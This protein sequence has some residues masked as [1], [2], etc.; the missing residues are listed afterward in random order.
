MWS[1]K[2]WMAITFKKLRTRISDMKRHEAATRS[3]A[4]CPEGSQRLGNQRHLAASSFSPRPVGRSRPSERATCLIISSKR[5]PYSDAKS[6]SDH[7][8]SDGEISRRPYLMTSFLPRVKFTRSWIM[9]IMRLLLCLRAVV[10][11]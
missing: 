5:W 6:T 3:P 1:N 11:P 2:R 9:K 4:S 10:Y 7:S 8:I